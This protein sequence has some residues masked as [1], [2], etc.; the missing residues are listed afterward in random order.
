MIFFLLCPKELFPIQAHEHPQQRRAS[1]SYS[2]TAETLTAASS[3]TGVV[4]PVSI[5]TYHLVTPKVGIQVT[6]K[7]IYKLIFITL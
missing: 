5:I 3:S 1:R 7:Q 2:Q 4:I 6:L